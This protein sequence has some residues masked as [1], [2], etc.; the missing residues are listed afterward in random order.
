M[1]NETREARDCLPSCIASF[2]WAKKARKLN[3]PGAQAL[4][5]RDTIKHIP[6]QKL[7]MPRLTR[8]H[9]LGKTLRVASSRMPDF[10]LGQPTKPCP[11]QARLCPG[12]AS[13]GALCDLRC[14]LAQAGDCQGG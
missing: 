12:L 13:A 11:G 3:K 7:Y 4:I 8:K 2:Q 5:L 6:R 10:C 9:T 1:S 14:E